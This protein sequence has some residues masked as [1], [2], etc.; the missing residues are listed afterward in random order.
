MKNVYVVKKIDS[1]DDPYDGWHVECI[2]K[3]FDSEEK[4]KKYIQDRIKEKI[5]NIDEDIYSREE[6]IED[7]PEYD[8]IKPDK[9]IVYYMYLD[10]IESYKYIT[11]EVE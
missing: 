3:I 5:E 8:D 11:Y 2:E 10:N 4:A 7:V 1:F 6:F 9:G